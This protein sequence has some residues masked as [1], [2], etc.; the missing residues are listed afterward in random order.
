MRFKALLFAAVIPA[1]VLT[2]C[3]KDS[4]NEP[5]AE[6][7]PAG[8]AA[9]HFEHYAGNT[10][11]SLGNSQGYVYNTPQGD[12]FNVTMY[13]YYVSNIKLVKADGSEYAEPE[14]YHLVNQ[15][16]ASSLSFDVAGIPAGSYTA[17]KLLLGVD[18]TR[19]V[20][21]A[22]TGAL[23]PALGMFWAWSTGYIMAKVEGDFLKTSTNANAVF[24]FH[25]GGFTGKNSV[26]NEI[27]LPLPQE[28]AVGDNTSSSLTLKSD[29][30]KWFNGFAP[31]DLQTLNQVGS[32]GVEAFDLARNFSYSFSV[33]KVQN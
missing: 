22:Q 28:L 25:L 9:F 21:G 17:V 27:T 1:A 7:G 26:L 20:S 24:S 11:L 14:S 18:S 5:V 6:P 4:K 2:G 19:N 12:Q 8:K 29:L 13:K 23:D 16:E 33:T 15:A 10:P 3:S 32:A 31:I 30:L